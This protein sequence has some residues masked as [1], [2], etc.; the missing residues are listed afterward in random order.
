M[1]GGGGF[2]I[3][4]TLTAPPES[5]KGG[6]QVSEENFHPTKKA[7]GGNT[8]FP[9]SLSDLV[10][11]YILGFKRKITLYLKPTL[12]NFLINTSTAKYIKYFED[13]RTHNLAEKIFEKFLCAQYQKF[14]KISL[15][16]YMYVCKQPRGN[17]KG[18]C[19]RRRF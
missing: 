5:F 4:C 9:P 3:T 1:L 16:V 6:E 17:Y 19:G 7:Q 11:M 14:L 18:E 12:E 10:H 15:D 8:P 2:F 13:R